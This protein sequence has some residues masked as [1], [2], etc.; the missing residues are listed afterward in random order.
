LIVVPSD[1][2]VALMPPEKVGTGDFYP[3][4]QV[5]ATYAVL[6]AVALMLQLLP[7]GASETQN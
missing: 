7:I 2:S 6:L 1:S 5:A 4:S 3:E